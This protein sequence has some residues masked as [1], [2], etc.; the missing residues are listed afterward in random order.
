MILFIKNQIYCWTQ[1]KLKKKKFKED[2]HS[3]DKFIM[4]AKRKIVIADFEDKKKEL[5]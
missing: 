4:H 1:I 5:K 3:W 2:P